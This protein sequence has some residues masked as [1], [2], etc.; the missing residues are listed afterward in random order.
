MFG[1]ESDSFSIL[2]VIRVE[3]ALKISVAK[4]LSVFLTVAE[5]ETAYLQWFRDVQ[6][7]AY[8]SVDFAARFR[9]RAW[10]HYSDEY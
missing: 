8:C 10:L 4:R 3:A 7:V 9:K 2:F 1:C 6:K 5:I